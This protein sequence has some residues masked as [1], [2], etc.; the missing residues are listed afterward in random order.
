M[1]TSLIIAIQI[2]LAILKKIIS[3]FDSKF[4]TNLA[5]KKLAS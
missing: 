2:I 3:G 5:D 1:T 4:L